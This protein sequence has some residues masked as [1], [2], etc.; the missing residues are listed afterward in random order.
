MHAIKFCDNCINIGKCDECMWNSYVQ[1]LF[2]AKEGSKSL[3]P[4]QIL[5]E[6]IEFKLNRFLEKSE[7]VL[8]RHM[9]SRGYSFS[10]MVK[11]LNYLHLT[12][13]SIQ[14]YITCKCSEYIT[15]SEYT[16]GLNKI[17][18]I[19][20]THDLEHIIGRELTCEN[21]RRWEHDSRIEC[22]CLEKHIITSCEDSACEFARMNGWL[23]VNLEDD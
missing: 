2:E 15:D 11:I 4:F 13:Y 14:D 9:L 20:K 19:I 10:E 3:S 5:K 7:I 8:V 12:N 21:C 17:S 23:S 6:K 1:D 18:N 16:E 22:V